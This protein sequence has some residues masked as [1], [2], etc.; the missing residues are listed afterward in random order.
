MNLLFL[1]LALD[2]VEMLFMAKK[3]REKEQENEHQ[4]D[5]IELKEVEDDQIKKKY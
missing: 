2:E 3:S 1:G 4:L 5:V